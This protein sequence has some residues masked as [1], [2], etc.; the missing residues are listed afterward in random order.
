MRRIC[1]QLMSAA[2]VFTLFTASLPSQ[3]VPHGIH[4]QAVARDN[5]GKELSDRSIDVRFSIISGTP[6]GPLVY[7][8]LHQAVHTSRYGVFTLVVGGGVPVGGTVGE[9]SQIS[10]GSAMHF[11]KVEIKFSNEFMDMGTMQFLSV[12]YA[13][14]AAKSLEPGPQGPPGPPGPQGPPG[15]PASGLQTL[16]F[17]GANLTISRG[18]TVNLSALINDADHD[19]NNEIQYLSL[20]GDTLS[21]TRGNF[22]TF[23]KL[24]VDD[25]D[26]DPTNE[27]QDLRLDGHILR[28]TGL[29]DPLLIDL[30]QY[31]DNRDEQSLTWNPATRMLGITNSTF[32]I[33]LSRVI[34]FNQGTGVLS[35]S[36]GNGVDLSS[37][38][39]DA[40]ADPTN[41]LITSLSLQGSELVVREGSNEKRVDLSSNMVGFRA[42]KTV[43]TAASSQA[44][45]VFIPGSDPEEN[46][47]N[48]FSAATG[49]FTA[50]VAGIYSFFISFF[51]DGSGSDR[52]LSLHKNLTEYEVLAD[53]ISAYTLTTR[54][55]TMRLSAGDVV[56]LVI[57][58]GTASQSGS[59]TFMGYRV[60]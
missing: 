7:Q 10:W 52:K 58:T 3:T 12:P 5:T 57:N 44:N 34:S 50:P 17:E 23:S 29:N 14:Y 54:S 19:P 24:N 40:D 26:A 38:K 2:A 55:I 28:I 45:I 1:L 53:N 15:D 13:L 59:G 6:L 47:G 22:V 32:Q 33:D 21:I 4:Y 18:N 11:L 16:S 31:L 9:L 56:R 36:G 27:L 48:G 35:I 43:S 46:F 25:A 30:S 51:A 42:K 20:K 37:L 39:N 49:E 8:E 41:E 60:Y